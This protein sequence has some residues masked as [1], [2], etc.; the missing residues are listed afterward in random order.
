MPGM[1]ATLSPAS[2]ILIS[3][4]RSALL[5]QLLIIALVCTLLLIAWGASRTAL[6]GSLARTP[7]AVA[8]R[9]WREPRARRVLRVG[10][11]LIW[12]FEIGRAHV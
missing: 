4:F 12:L 2:P 11:G 3:A 7:A 5:H 9:P 8:I 6:F 10:F 1:N